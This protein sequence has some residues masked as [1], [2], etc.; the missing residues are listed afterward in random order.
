M[1][2]SYGGRVGEVGLGG[3]GEDVEGDGGEGEGGYYFRGGRRVVDERWS[4]DGGMWSWCG[5]CDECLSVSWGIR[6]DVKI[7]VY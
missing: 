2:V 4:G 5:L 7:F 1:E 3:E 6:G